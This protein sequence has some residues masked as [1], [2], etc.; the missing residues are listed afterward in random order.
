MQLIFTVAEIRYASRVGSF[1][2]TRT[3]SKA[4]L[5]SVVLGTTVRFA[6]LLPLSH[7]ATGEL[8]TFAQIETDL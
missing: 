3:A 6:K 4:T 2:E 5:L 1:S 8:A 7:E